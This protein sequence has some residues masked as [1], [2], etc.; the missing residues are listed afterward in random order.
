MDKETMIKMEEELRDSIATDFEYNYFIEAGAGAGKTKLVVDRITNQLKAGIKPEKI[1]AITFTNKAAQELCK[2]ISENLRKVSPSDSDYSIVQ[3]ALRDIGRMQV[4][5]IHSFCYRILKENCFDAKL[6]LDFELLEEDDTEKQKKEFFNNWFNSNSKLFTEFS[7]VSPSDFF[8]TDLEKNFI[9]IC[10]LPDRVVFKYEDYD[11]VKPEVIGQISEDLLKLKEKFVEAYISAIEQELQSTGAD[12][13]PIKGLSYT[14]PVTEKYLKDKYKMTAGIDGIYAAIL[15][16]SCPFRQTGNKELGITVNKELK[17]TFQ[18]IGENAFKAA[19]TELQEVTVQAEQLANTK[20]ALVNTLVMQIILLARKAYKQQSF[21]QYVTNDLLL[22]KTNELLNVPSVVEKLRKSYSCIY[23]DEF[24]DTDPIQNELILKICLKDGDFIPGLLF[25]VGDVKQSIYKFRQADYRLFNEAKALFAAHPKTCKVASLNINNRSNANLVDFF[26]TSVKSLPSGLIP[27]YIEMVP[28]NGYRND[29]VLHGVYKVIDNNPFRTD[30]SDATE[31]EKIVGIIRHLLGRPI[32]FYNTETNAVEIKEVEY[33]DFLILTANAR[34]NSEYVDTLQNMGIPARVSEEYMPGSMSPLKR[35]AAIYQYLAMPYYNRAKEGLLEIAQQDTSFELKYNGEKLDAW[36]KE[37]SGMGGA[38]LAGWLLAQDARYLFS[39]SEIAGC[40]VKRYQMAIRQMIDQVISTCDDNPIAVADAI[41]QY[42]SEDHFCDREIGYDKNENAV[43]LMNI[44]KAKGLEGNIVIIAQRKD[45]DTNDSTYTEGNDRYQV[46]ANYN[47]KGFPNKR[48]S[49]YSLKP[50]I[51]TKADKERDMESA[52][53]E[54]VAVT[55]AREA[56]IFMDHSGATADSSMFANYLESDIKELFDMFPVEEGVELLKEPEIKDAKEILH[57]ESPSEEVRAIRNYRV[58]PSTMEIH[59]GFMTKDGEDTLKEDL[60]EP[61]ELKDDNIQSEDDVSES[62]E[63]L[64]KRPS[65]D[66]FGTTM[67][68]AF[69]LA[70]TEIRNGREDY[71]LC[72]NRAINENSDDIELRY[73][74]SAETEKEAFK[75]Y[76]TEKLPA[77]VDQIKKDVLGADEVY[78]EYPFSLTISGDDLREM[79]SKIIIT[80]KIS[81]SL[82]EDGSEDLKTL[83]INGIADLVIRKG[84]DVVIWDYKSDK[85]AELSIED[86][87]K[88][89]HDTYDNQMNLYKWV[90]GKKYSGK[91][92][93]KFYSVEIGRIE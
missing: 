36:R 18:S 45:T 56:L 72:I 39:D 27:D 82:P 90:F 81:K 93:G 13:T 1:V 38:A 46:V 75:A 17:Q 78:T 28:R 22:Q 92:D 26:N 8:Y 55:R 47:G 68:R 51:K 79:K 34:G 91:I 49:A 62:S 83:W 73:K 86:F 48:F 42:V 59:A 21:N 76:L 4:S 41:K 61:A 25:L 89:I 30:V 54:Y 9:E 58:S 69:E 29:D 12:G 44:H 88:K 70:I 31:P 60:F 64:Q 67:H 80:D 71:G 85:M 7:K 19:E 65:G 87:I 52:R 3:Q 10:E 11:D 77:F 6:R 84:E 74:S 35:F 53:L 57:I 16:S 33:K 23:V 43:R 40:K 37:T 32:S 2:R 14:D 15:E 24:Q 66:I 50:I 63:L 5:T 20:C